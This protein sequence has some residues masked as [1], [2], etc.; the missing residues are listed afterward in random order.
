MVLILIVL[1]IYFRL[2]DRCLKVAE[3][4]KKRAEEESRQRAEDARLISEGIKL[5]NDEKKKRAHE[6]H[7]GFDVEVVR[8]RVKFADSVVLNLKKKIEEQQTYEA[9]IAAAQEAALAEKQA[10]E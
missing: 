3:E 7:V 5:K 1:V 10:R 6:P 8:N 2:F 4:T 9:K